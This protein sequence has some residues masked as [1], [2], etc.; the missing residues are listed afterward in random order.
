MIQSYINNITNLTSNTSSVNFQTDCIRTNSCNCN[1]CQS[2]LCHNQG[3]AGYDI[4]KG[5]LYEID[6]N[7]SVS[8]ATVGVVAFALFN[9]DEEIPGTRMVETLGA[10]NDYVNIGI[11]K[12][13]RVCCNGNANITVQSVPTVPTPSDPTTPIT[14]QIPI[15]AS[16]NFSITKLNG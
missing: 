13:I 8:S 9:N 5:G 12:K 11:D 16:A 10:A 7:A 1:S 2:W 15:I 4:V 6:F 3:F 14:T